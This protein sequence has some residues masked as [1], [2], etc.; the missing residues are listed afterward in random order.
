MNKLFVLC[1]SLTILAFAVLPATVSAADLAVTKIGTIPLNGKT[2][3]H[4]WFE[5]TNLTMEG[6]G[7]LGANIDVTIDGNTQTIKASVDNGAWKYTHPSLLEKK[8]HNVM[9]A[10]GDQKISF[11]LTIGAASVPADQLASTDAK[12]LP[13]TGNVLPMLGLLALVGA[14]LY[15]G[16]RERKV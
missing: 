2:Y 12:T 10:S 7:S 9:V 15:F 8:D 5:P 16:F 1:V 4:F 13:T 14:F 3:N 11:I 6:T